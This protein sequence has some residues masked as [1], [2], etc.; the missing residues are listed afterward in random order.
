MPVES[1]RILDTPGKSA[2]GVIEC[3]THIVGLGVAAWTN[4]LST[5]MLENLDQVLV[6]R[7]GEPATFLVV[8]EDIIAPEVD[9]RVEGGVNILGRHRGSVVEENVDLHLVVLQCNERQTQS[10]RL[11]EEEAERQVQ[12]FDL[13]E[14]SRWIVEI[15][16]FPVVFFLTVGVVEFRPQARPRGVVLVNSLTPNLEFNLLDERLGGEIGR[17]RISLLHLDFEPA[18]RKQISVT[19]HRCGKP[20]S[21]SSGA[22]PRGCDRFDRERRVPAVQRLEET[23]GGVSSEINILAAVG[24]CRV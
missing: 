4:G 22:I 12:L 24:D 7:L 9:L 6:T 23:N 8:E 10:W 18:I 2:H 3:Q 16:E 1:R 5:S 11:R 13:S 21:P 19:R 15:S 14:I 20:L 17:A